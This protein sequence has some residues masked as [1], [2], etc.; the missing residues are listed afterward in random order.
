MF[1]FFDPCFECFAK[2]D[3]F[4]AHIFDYSCL[5]RKAYCYGRGS[6]LYKIVC[7]KTFLKMAGGRMHIPHPT[8]LD[9]P[10]AISCRNH[11]K[12]L[13]YFNHLASLI[14]FFFTKM[15]SQNG[16]GR[17]WHNAPHLNTLVRLGFSVVT[18]LVKIWQ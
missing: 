8:P 13:A 12:S 9:P 5:R 1:K 14:L 15:Q 17:A 7:T 10:L 2:Y 16:G 11:Q 4:C 6:K 18:I 3:A